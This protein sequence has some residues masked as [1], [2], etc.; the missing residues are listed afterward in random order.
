MVFEPWFLL[1]GV[2]L[3]LAGRDFLRTAAIEVLGVAFSL[4]HLHVAV[5]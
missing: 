1:E 5:S 2:L 4:A 3:A